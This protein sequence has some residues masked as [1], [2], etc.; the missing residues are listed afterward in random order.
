MRFGGIL[1]AG[2]LGLA[3]PAGPAFAQASQTPWT[4]AQT[5]MSGPDVAICWLKLGA[6]GPYAGTLRVDPELKARP[7]ILALVGVWEPVAGPAPSDL[8]EV[9]VPQEAILYR[10][11]IDRA[12]TAIRNGEPP[13]SVLEPLQSLPVT[14]AYVRFNPLQSGVFSFGR[15]DAYAILALLLGEEG[16]QTSPQQGVIDAVLSAWES[17]LVG[18][19]DADLLTADSAELATS[20]ARHGDRVSARRVL[21]RLSPD[22]EPGLIEGLIDLGLFEE[23]VAVSEAAEPARSLPRL[24]RERAEIERNSAAQM[25]EFAALQKAAFEEMLADAPEEQRAALK[26]LLAEGI[27]EFEAEVEAEAQA[28]AATTDSLDDE[29]TEA[30]VDELALARDRLM[31]EADRA[32]KAAL[33]Q[34]MA[35]QVV[36]D[37]MLTPEMMA[38][39]SRVARGL[40]LFVRTSTPSEAIALTEQV[41]AH[42]RSY[43]DGHLQMVLPAIYAAWQ[44]LDRP[45][46]AAALIEEWRPIAM[47]QGRAFADR[48][49]NTRLLPGDGQPGA[50]QGLQAILVSRDDIAGAEALGWLN[51]DTGLRRDFEAGRGISR[52]DEHLSRTA[53]ESRG[54]VLISC[55]YL[56][57]EARDLASA[58][59]CTKR[60]A[61]LAD[62]DSS[63]VV[64]VDGLF[65]VA[66]AAAITDDLETA[67]PLVRRALAMG[68]GLEEQAST[69][70]AFSS[71]LNI[72]L[73]EIA[74]A[75][76]RRD[77]RLAARQRGGR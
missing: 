66:T 17:D 58:A 68:A 73:S 22:D 71:S 52:L 28:A 42:A 55:R 53:P 72:R 12:T 51:P 64:A 9:E 35:R 69:E 50:T 16:S 67:L 6:R 23:A 45:D 44:R 65:Q 74:K 41:E 30:A 20:Y 32:G 63:R 40:E 8:P 43:R 49:R 7:D 70:I 38:S 57:L 48:D 39:G 21:G 34:S 18:V 46:R 19:N 10:E 11:A 14:G 3:T 54:S 26:D 31:S 60:F 36:A 61:T 2:L 15:L 37:A 27:A 77:G 47:A 13:E 5:C 4:D 59:V 1:I 29:L 24:R 75:M 62:T 76:L 56:A 33:V 25:R